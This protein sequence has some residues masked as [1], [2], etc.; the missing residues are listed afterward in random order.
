MSSLTGP[1]TEPPSGT[2][3]HLVVLLHGYGSNGDDLIGLVPYLKEALPEALYVS[4]NAPTPCEINPGGYEW[5]DLTSGDFSHMGEQAEGVRPVLSEYLETLWA[6]TGLGPAE[7]VLIGFS[8]GTMMALHTALQLK[9]PVA[10]VVGF[11]GS[12]PD[13]NSA[14]EGIVSRPPVL[15]VHGTHDPVVEHQFAERSHKA[16]KDGGVDVTLKSIDG[17]DHGIDT[18]GLEAAVSFLKG[19]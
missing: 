11:S 6:E 8:Q 14:G 1:R 19:L 5:F 10:G 13:E 2:P 17:L 18:Q 16:L 4:P 7:T 9:A 12:L 3:S 15:L